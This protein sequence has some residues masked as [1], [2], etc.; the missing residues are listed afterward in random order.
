[1]VSS[2]ETLRKTKIVVQKLLKISNLTG[3]A[4]IPKKRGSSP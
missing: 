1:V 2:L 4:L 3:M